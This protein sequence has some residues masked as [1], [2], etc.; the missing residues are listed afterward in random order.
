MAESDK[1]QPWEH[2]GAVVGVVGALVSGIANGTFWSLAPVFAER[3]GLSAGG[4]AS[5]KI[6]RV[7]V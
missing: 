1:K 2:V 6:G 5:F 7:H 3:S 4:V